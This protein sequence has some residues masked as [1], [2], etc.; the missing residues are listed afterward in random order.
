MTYSAAAPELS[1][2]HEVILRRGGPAIGEG[3]IASKVDISEEKG[4]GP[5][6]SPIPDRGPGPTEGEEKEISHLALPR[7][8]RPFFFF[9]ELR[10]VLSLVPGN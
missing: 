1:H 2:K 6:A 8:S 9:F 10:P 5:I 3:G 7:I 4:N